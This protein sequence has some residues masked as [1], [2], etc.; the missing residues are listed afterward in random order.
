M[1]E[2]VQG[3]H[4]S[5]DLYLE[6]ENAFP[7]PVDLTDFDE[8]SICLEQTDGAKLEITQDLNAND[9]L[10]EKISPDTN[11][12]LRLTLDTLDSVNLRSGTHSYSVVRNNSNI[13][14]KKIINVYNG[15]KV[16]ES[17]C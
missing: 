14:N 8:F 2:I 13:P 10:I 17:G 12:H 11:G 4:V 16:E 5:V 1:I 9:S 7:R 15:V 6:R 3:E